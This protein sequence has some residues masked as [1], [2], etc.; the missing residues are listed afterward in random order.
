MMEALNRRP[1]GDENRALQVAL[2]LSMSNLNST[3][4]SLSTPAPPTGLFEETTPK[5]KPRTNNITECV[6]VPSSEHVAEIVGRQ[7]E[8]LYV[9]NVCLRFSRIKHLLIVHSLVGR[10]VKTCLVVKCYIFVR[11]QN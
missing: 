9:S 6:P 5:Q 2:E 3:T 7:G 10:V 8:G 11:L 4:Y 1:F